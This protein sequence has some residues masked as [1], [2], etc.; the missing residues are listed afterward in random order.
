MDLYV[1]SMFCTIRWTCPLWSV[2]SRTSV[3]CGTPFRSNPP[4]GHFTLLLDRKVSTD[5]CCHVANLLIIIFF[6]PFYDKVCMH[7]CSIEELAGLFVYKYKLFYIIYKPWLF[8]SGYW[9]YN[10]IILYWYIFIHVQCNIHC[11]QCYTVS[12]YVPVSV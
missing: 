2:F 6:R 9:M 7:D 1:F 3:V 4:L 8:H 10:Y 11:L 12:Q 5:H